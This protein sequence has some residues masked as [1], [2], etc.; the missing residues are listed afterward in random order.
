M[1]IAF[2]VHNNHLAKI[3]IILCILPVISFAITSRAK[4]SFRIRI[5]LPKSK[6]FGVVNKRT[7]RYRAN[8]CAS[9]RAACLAACSLA[10]FRNGCGNRRRTGTWWHAAGCDSRCSGLCS[11]SSFDAPIRV[12][13]LRLSTSTARRFSWKWI[14]WESGRVDGSSYCSPGLFPGKGELSIWMFGMYSI[15]GS[16]HLLQAHHLLL[17]EKSARLVG[18]NA[19]FGRRLGL[20]DELF[21]YDETCSSRSQRGHCLVWFSRLQIESASIASWPLDAENGLAS[22]TVGAHHFVLH[23]DRIIRRSML[24][25][26]PW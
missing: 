24:P 4:K 25:G 17:L 12:E 8:G 10:P 22:F 13:P 18:W 11:W 26:E 21:R 20:F 19:P 6:S 15:D 3:I 16:L 1:R 5:H 9:F 2:N 7:S 23:V 14:D